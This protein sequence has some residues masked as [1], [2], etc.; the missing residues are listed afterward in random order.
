MHTF[1]EAPLNTPLSQIA[2]LPEGSSSM[3]SVTSVGNRHYYNIYNHT[4][5]YK[6]IKLTTAILPNLSAVA[7]VL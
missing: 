5:D 2:R 6:F 7:N 3:S 4:I 1:C